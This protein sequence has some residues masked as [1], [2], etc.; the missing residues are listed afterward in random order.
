MSQAKKILEGLVDL[1]K[2]DDISPQD[3][4]YLEAFKRA[5]LSVKV[6]GS[7]NALKGE[8][9]DNSVHI[10]FEIGGENLYLKFK[11]GMHIKTGHEE[12]AKNL[13]LFLRSVSN[14]R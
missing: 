8:M 6:E 11:N 5:G 2:V 10:E 7:G 12:V 13:S 9:T 14:H 4:K 3:K 1:Y